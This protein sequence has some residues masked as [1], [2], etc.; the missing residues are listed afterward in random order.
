MTA[1]E[2]GINVILGGSVGPRIREGLEDSARRAGMPFQ[3]YRKT[4]TGFMAALQELNRLCGMRV[5][6][7]VEEECFD[8]VGHRRPA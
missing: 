8:H 4:H 6:D 5:Y 2:I 3:E 1:Y 7:V